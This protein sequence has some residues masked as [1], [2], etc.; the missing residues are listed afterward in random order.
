M[1]IIAAGLYEGK[2]IGGPRD[3]V[4]LSA[5]LQWD[6]RIRKQTKEGETTSTTYP[7]FY[8]WMDAS[9]DEFG[10][11]YTWVWQPDKEHSLSPERGRPRKG[12]HQSW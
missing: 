11:N 2:A 3:G 12:Y 8:K 6:G 7:G 9:L 4:K 10:S 5:S 1:N